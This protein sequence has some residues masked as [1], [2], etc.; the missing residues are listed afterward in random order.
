MYMYIYRIFF[1]ILIL[2]DKFLDQL[3]YQV[4]QMHGII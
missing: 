3:K 1:N 4:Q 2:K